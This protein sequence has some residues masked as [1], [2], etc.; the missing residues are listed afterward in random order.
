MIEQEG[1]H[2]RS[3]GGRDTHSL[4]LKVEAY[5]RGMPQREALH[6][7]ASPLLHTTLVLA[8]GSTERETQRTRTSTHTHI[9]R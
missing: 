6:S 1:A 2:A 3:G 8:A 4:H 7:G 5:V 9:E